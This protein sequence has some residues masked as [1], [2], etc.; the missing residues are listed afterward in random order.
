MRVI[1]QNVDT[2]YSTFYCSL[3][4]LANGMFFLIVFNRDIG[5]QFYDRISVIMLCVASVL[6]YISQYLMTIASKYE[7]ATV[8]APMSYLTTSMILVVDIV[9]FQYEF[10]PLYFVGFVIILV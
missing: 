1:G 10:M 2:V 8:L 7:K 5:I 3:G 4:I 6:N 9:I